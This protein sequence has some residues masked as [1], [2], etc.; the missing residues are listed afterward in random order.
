MVIF[1]V[2]ILKQPDFGAAM[3]LA[4]LTFALLFISGT[5]L[6]YLASL[7]LFALPVVILLVL[8]PYRLKRIT[9]FLD[10]WKEPQ[11]CG[12]NSVQSFIA[13]GSGGYDGVGLGSFQTEISVSAGVA[14]GLHFFDYR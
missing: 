1:Q 13:L 5:R 7:A 8:K 6:R 14:Y 4:F 12:F 11:G 3:S 10:P 2:V 9:C